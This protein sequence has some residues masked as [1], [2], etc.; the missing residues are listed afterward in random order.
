MTS[1][2]LEADTGFWVHSQMR[3]RFFFE[4]L[5]HLPPPQLRFFH[6]YSIY[7]NI[8]LTG[9]KAPPSQA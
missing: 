9:A 8:V 3:S 5:E 1:A 6:D 4:V 7:F 2:C